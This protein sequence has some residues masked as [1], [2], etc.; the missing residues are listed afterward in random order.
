MSVRQI[1]N[2][3]AIFCSVPD[4]RKSAAVRGTVEGPITPDV[5]ASI[6]QSHPQTC[7]VLD[8]A[9]ASQLSEATLAAAERP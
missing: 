6:L 2:S 7:L 8:E 4:A 1:L 5:P 9:A 3:N